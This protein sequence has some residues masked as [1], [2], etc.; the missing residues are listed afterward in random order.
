M[1]KK[2]ITSL[3]S[4]SGG[5][6]CDAGKTYAIMFAVAGGL[7]ANPVA[8]LVSTAITMANYANC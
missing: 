2:D 4:L 7:F 5:Y 8:L 3:E 1:K 6:N